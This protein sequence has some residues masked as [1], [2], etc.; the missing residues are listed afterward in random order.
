MLSENDFLIPATKL[1]FSSI[2]TF[3]FL[4]FGDQKDIFKKWLDKYTTIEDLKV[5]SDEL[6]ELRNSL[7]H[8]TNYDSRKNINGD[9]ARLMIYAGIDTSEYSNC[10]NSQKMIHYPSLYDTIHSGVKNWLKDTMKNENEKDLF[11]DRYKY[12]ASDFRLDGLRL[13]K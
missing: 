12:I 3:A 13:W 8:M 1:L 5:S 11:I 6:W 9:V 2:D 4:C 7:I 10:N